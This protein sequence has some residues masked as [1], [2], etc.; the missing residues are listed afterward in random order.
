M[1]NITCCFTGHRP[2]KIFGYD[3][4]NPKYQNMAKVIKY[5]AKMLYLNYGVKRFI[6][7]GAL[8][9]DTVSFFAIESLK[10]EYNDIQNI[11]AI[12]F[13]NQNANWKSKVDLDRYDRM[14]KLADETIMVD[15]I[16]KYKA[17]T[18]GKKLDNRN[19]YMVDNS[20]YIITYHNGSNGGTKN[21][22]DYAKR[23]GVTNIMNII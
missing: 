4:S 15:E 18:I 19:H 6:T 21:C 7:G 11:L 16:D 3:L 8:G 12:P 2:N 5:Y 17:N 22:L 13:K 20:N 23:N 1:K 10:K 14:L 9:F